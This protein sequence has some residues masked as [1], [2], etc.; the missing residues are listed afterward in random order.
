MTPSYVVLVAVNCSDV[1][2]IPVIVPVMVLPLTT[3]SVV[4][5]E[6][7]PSLNAPEVGLVMGRLPG[8]ESS[9]YVPV[10]SPPCW[11][12][13]PVPGAIL[14]IRDPERS[15]PTRQPHSHFEASSG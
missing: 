1:P 4:P 2:S 10:T 6:R 14:F 7:T 13:A 9:K 12:G 3:A 11:V 15:R 8:T 5:Y